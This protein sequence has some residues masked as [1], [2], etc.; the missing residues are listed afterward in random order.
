MMFG[1]GFG[2]D[3]MEYLI[4]VNKA[5]VD[6]ERDPPDGDIAKAYYQESD[7]QA[8]MIAMELL[9]VLTNACL[10]AARHKMLFVTCELNCLQREFLRQ[11]IEPAKDVLPHGLWD[12]F[13]RIDLKHDAD[14]LVDEFVVTG[15]VSAY[16]FVD[17]V[18]EYLSS[19]V[20]WHLSPGS[21]SE[22][23]DDD[24][25]RIAAAEGLSAL[26]I[27]SIKKALVIPDANDLLVAGAYTAPGVQ[28]DV[29]EHSVFSEVGA[30]RGWLMN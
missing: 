27:G 6:N 5:I 9:L 29:I 26:R 10:D 15:P 23:S 11:I 14:D 13:P 20:L 12:K 24:L 25:E 28:S 19:R 8:K 17:A 2:F 4:E 22:L 21:L 3:E 18:E 16:D 1:F 30:A 7:Y